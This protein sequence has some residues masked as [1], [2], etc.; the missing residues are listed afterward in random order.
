MVPTAECS[1]ISLTEGPQ[2]DALSCVRFDGGEIT[3]DVGALLLGLVEER[4]P[5]LHRFAGCFRDNRDPARIEHSVQQLV[6]QLVYAIAL[7]HKDVNDHDTLRLD[8]L[9]AALV[10][11]ADPKGAKRSRARDE[12][13]GLAASSTLHRLELAHPDIAPDDRN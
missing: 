13:K 2:A 12:G 6:A 10:G 3:S 5:I 7:G 1:P 8:A 9:H 11:Q 4:R